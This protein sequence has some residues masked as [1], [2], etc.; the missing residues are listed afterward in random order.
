MSDVKN[1]GQI[2]LL[3]EDSIDDYEATERALR[4][5][6][7]YNTVRWMSSGEEAMQYLRQEGPFAADPE[8]V[9]PGIILLDLNMPGMDGRRVL[10]Q[11]KG[12]PRLRSIPVVVLTTS[13][14]ERDIERC[15]EFGANTYI[16]KPV[17]FVGLIDAVRSLKEYWFEIALLPK[18]KHED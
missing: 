2:I 13:S 14:D 9:R 12:D 5:S 16:Q 1:K 15:Y 4:K 10:Q 18:S 11:I 8:A 3:V 17:S 7:L 6:N